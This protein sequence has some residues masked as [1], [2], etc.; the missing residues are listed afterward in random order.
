[1]MDKIESVVQAC[2]MILGVIYAL[3]MAYYKELKYFYELIKKV[4]LQMCDERLSPRVLGL[5]N[6]IYAGLEDFFSCPKES[7]LAALLFL[8]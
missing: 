5:K 6:K 1:M 4:L 2:A 8:F 3:N 7:S